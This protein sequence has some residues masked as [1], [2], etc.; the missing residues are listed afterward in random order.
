M[1]Y[2]LPN[3]AYE[4]ARSFVPGETVVATI[5]GVAVRGRFPGTP[6]IDRAGAA[7]LLSP[8][9]LVATVPADWGTVKSAAIVFEPP[10]VLLYTAPTAAAL[11]CRH[12]AG[13]TFYPR[14][15]VTADFVGNAGTRATIDTTSA[16]PM[17]EIMEPEIDCPVPSD[18][19][20][21]GYADLAIGVPGDRVGVK[22]RAGAV[23]VL[24]GGLSGLT[25][26]GS[27]W[28]TQDRAGVLGVS[29]TGDRFGD[30]VATGDFD[31]DGYAD[32]AIG[33]PLDQFDGRRAGA[34]NVLYGSR[35]G[36]TGDGNQRWS[37]ANL[38]GPAGEIDRFGQELATGDF[39]GDGYDDLA[40]GVP[41]DDV[42][43]ADDL[44]VIDVLY[45]GPG[46]LSADRAATF[47]RSATGATGRASGFFGWA[48]AAGD[49]DDDGYVDLAVGAPNGNPGGT[50]DVGVL[51]GGPAGLAAA[52][53]QSWSQASPGIAG[54]PNRDDWFGESL[55]IGDFDR[56]GIEDLAI[57]APG[58]DALGNGDQQGSVAVLY[59]TPAGPT[60][61]RSQRWHQDVPNV[62]GVAEANEWFG[63]ALAA[64]DFDG[65]GADDVAIGVIGDRVG[66]V[67]AGAVNV[68][69][70]ST[71]GIT[72]A[73]AQRWTQASEGVPGTPETN[74]WFGASLSIAN[75]GRSARH[76]LVI[77][78]PGESIGRGGQDGMVN[79]LYGRSTG[80]TS[81]HAQQWWQGSPG[82][83]G[84][85][86]NP[87][88][89]GSG[90]T[91]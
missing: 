68:L 51:F 41:W 90:L 85:P 91:P 12:H 87:D 79:V 43:G 3:V 64:G 89:F 67:Y 14:I 36:L 45:G 72:A 22:D 23:N 66:R 28:W 20:G 31:R 54:E 42:V 82:I 44:G 75:F 78:V 50:G 48:L 88:G 77:G 84:S 57:G 33:A 65:D 9:T 71:G 10:V 34:V 37:R 47:D 11:D 58:D 35:R 69:Y 27:Q 46:G 52:R 4:S 60:A 16:I 29:R 25:A 59:G 61:D 73:R 62:P 53:S 30:A 55:A 63:E 49:L 80:L 8:T 38:P 18:F 83:A 70:G 86:E 40:V 56:D 5:T 15:G 19:D 76:D 13:A 24:Y 26:A 21:D 7:E 74:D 17:A 2:G 39:D 81:A 6:S 1:E 32:L